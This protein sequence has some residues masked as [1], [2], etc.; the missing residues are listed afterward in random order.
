MNSIDDDAVFLLRKS[1][2]NKMGFSLKSP[3]NFDALIARV[4]DENCETLSLSTIKRLWGYIDSPTTPRLS[5]L[6]IL[7]R[8][9]G[10]RDF[11][12]F[13]RKKCI[14]TT[15]DSEFISLA[16]EEVKGFRIGDEL[17]LEWKPGRFCRI[18]Y[19]DT[20]TFRVAS[21]INCKLMKGDTFRATFVAVGH[22]LYVTDLMRGGV[23]LRDYVAAKK[24]GLTSVNIK[25]LDE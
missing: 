5:T 25:H 2:E 11:D 24:S 17:M 9:V 18:K 7:S 23:H 8:F 16:G 10:C 13:C 19:V 12:D 22:P 1:V 3:T 4:M 20:D 14:F 15:E 6:S 21:A